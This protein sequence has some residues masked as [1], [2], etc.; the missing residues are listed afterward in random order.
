MKTRYD[1]EVAVKIHEAIETAAKLLPQG[2]TVIIYI[3]REGYNV[4]IGYTGGTMSI[5]GTD[6]LAGDILEA[7]EDAITY[8]ANEEMK[9]VVYKGRK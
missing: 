9:A 3:E 1:I 5:T 8:A 4:E 7:T 2:Y 6:S